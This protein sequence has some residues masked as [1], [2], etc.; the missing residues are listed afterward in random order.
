VIDEL[1]PELD[2]EKLQLSNFCLLD[3]RETKNIELYMTKLG[4]NRED[5]YR[6]DVYR[7]I[8]EV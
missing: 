1:N 4:A 5:F 3:D 8:I 7:Y 2:S 6:S